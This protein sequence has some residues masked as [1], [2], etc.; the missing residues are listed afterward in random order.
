MGTVP[1]SGGGGVG[2]RIE[3]PTGLAQDMRLEQVGVRICEL[4]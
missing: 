3:A 4:G 2:G 1:G